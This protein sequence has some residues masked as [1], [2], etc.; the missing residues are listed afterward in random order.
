VPN[1]EL[2]LV[3]NK[4]YLAHASPSN[5]FVFFFS[6]FSKNGSFQ[7]CHIFMDQNIPKWGKYTEFAQTIPN[8]HMQNIPN[9]P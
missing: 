5:S 6:S 7:G 2:N 1:V 8:G 9:R 4:C 3:E